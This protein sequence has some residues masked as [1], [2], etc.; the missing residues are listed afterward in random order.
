MALAAN[1]LDSLLSDLRI[2]SNESKRKFP[3]LKEA[4]E[5]AVMKVRTLS[6][7]NNQNI[8]VRQ[9]LFEE[10]ARILEPFIMGCE[11]KQNQKVVQ[12]SL[13]A[14]QRMITHQ[15][16]SPV[17][18]CKLVDCLWSLVENNLEEVKV[19]Q[20]ATLLLSTNNVVS[21]PVLARTI[22]LCFRLHNHEKT[23][24]ASIASATI[25]QLVSNVFER[26]ENEDAVQQSFDSDDESDNITSLTYQPNTNNNNQQSSYAGHQQLHSQQHYHPNYQHKSKDCDKVDYNELNSFISGH[27]VNLANALR[28]QYAPRSLKASAADAFLLLRDLVLILNDEQSLWLVGLT[29]ISKVFALEL[30]EI[31]FVSF[32]DV[33]ARHDEFRYLIRERVCSMILDMFSPD[34]SNDKNPS[35]ND[36]SSKQRLDSKQATANQQTQSTNQPQQPLPQQT[37]TATTNK[38]QQRNSKSDQQSQ[39]ANNNNQNFGNNANNSGANSNTMNDF[40][41]VVADI[42]S[43]LEANREIGANSMR[44]LRILSM[45]IQK[46]YIE[47]MTNGDIF[48]AIF[49]KLLENDSNLKQLSSP[50]KL[51]RLSSA[52]T[53]TAGTTILS[54]SSSDIP[55]VTTM[56]SKLFENSP[57]LKREHLI[58]VVGDLC[59][60]NTSPY[61]IT[62]LLELGLVNLHRIGCIWEC[63][64]GHFLEVTRNENAEIRDW[65]SCASTHLIKQAFNYSGQVADVDNSMKQKQQL[66]TSREEKEADMVDVDSIGMNQRRLL[67]PLH[68][69]SQIPHPDIRQKQLEVV[70]QAI[71][72][73]TTEFTPAGWPQI[74]DIVGAVEDWQTDN[75]IRVAF[76]CLQ[77]I[78]SDYMSQID[79]ECVIL[80]IAAI[81]KFASQM[82]DLNVS[83]TAIGLLWNVAD[84][85]QQN[86]KMI[87]DSTEKISFD[88]ESDA[89]NL[90]PFIYDYVKSTDLN[91]YESIWMA[92]FAKLNELCVD[93]RPAIRKSACQTLFATI[94]THGDMLDER[95]WHSIIWQILFPLLHQVRTRSSVAVD[96]SPRQLASS[97]LNSMFA[98][99]SL[100]SGVG[101]GQTGNLGDED[102][103]NS[104]C[105]SLVMHHSRNTAQKQW[106]ETQVLALMGVTKIFIV[107]RDKLL[108]MQNF[109]K[110]W[111]VLIDFIRNGTLSK[112]FEVSMASLKCMQDLLSI[113]P[114]PKSYIQTQKVDQS[115]QLNTSNQQKQREQMESLCHHLDVQSW[116]SI[117]VM[118]LI[119]LL[120]LCDETMTTE[121]KEDFARCCFEALYQYSLFI[122]VG[123]PDQASQQQPV[124]QPNNNNN[125]NQQIISQITTDQNAEANALQ[126]AVNENNVNNNNNNTDS[127]YDIAA[128]IPITSS[129]PS[130]KNVANNDNTNAI[131]SANE[132]NHH[133][134]LNNSKSISNQSKDAQII[135]K[136]SLDGLTNRFME[137]IIRYSHDERLAGKCPLPRHRMSEVIFVLRAMTTLLKS[138]KKIPSPV[139]GSQV[140][141]KVLSL[142]PYLI[143]FGT[144][145]SP[146]D[147]IKRDTLNEVLLEYGSLLRPPPFQNDKANQI[148]DCGTI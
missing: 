147:Q 46:F 22:V 25:R 113:E 63:L 85:L 30:L 2:I 146:N 42:K 17:A 16:V 138:L 86:K 67:H 140:W 88:N 59:R 141:N 50:L 44:I 120:P 114:T 111:N 72:S 148:D 40:I 77:A 15:A 95:I 104:G 100:I 121:L 60:L 143:D 132:I 119:N 55:V 92:L 61:V 129:S 76:Q 101:G 18:A 34:I 122:N 94:T 24:V 80:I 28:M 145:N 36:T 21:G 105:D 71:Q 66:A 48:T 79:C 136:L 64:T 82:H 62:K 56:I 57:L 128:E 3:P 84:Y 54:V 13:N 115:K 4:A 99:E 35:Q 27:L 117:W 58:C 107:K 93:S 7:K 106:S 81:V 126:T 133:D 75:L 65:G 74:I 127:N 19:L 38:S 12:I 68:C 102:S 108:K 26:V 124:L 14:I 135:G 110:A 87:Q 118:P 8:D 31:A 11:F 139:A 33:L 10:S 37:T 6:S 53:G 51:T 131:N 43:S 98:T 137:V 89:P 123:S 9:A 83:L 97:S 70:L 32:S 109:S 134:L 130:S 112:L 29:D 45:L 5:A 49:R 142:Y 1:P 69:L 90:A 73:A 23:I 41:S 47:L 116:L 20:T 39:I 52:D 144:R 78:V 125:N 103:L 91:L 96:I